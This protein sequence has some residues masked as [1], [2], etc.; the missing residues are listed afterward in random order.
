MTLG[1]AEIHILGH[2]VAHRTGF[3]C[4]HFLVVNRLPDARDNL[5]FG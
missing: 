3:E 1:I 5:S 4:G 2:H